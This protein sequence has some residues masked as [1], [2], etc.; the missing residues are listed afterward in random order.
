MADGRAQRRRCLTWILTLLALGHLGWN[1][2]R[3]V[4]GGVLKRGKRIS[5][6]REAGPVG[7]HFD[8]NRMA[9]GEL[10]EWIRQH[11]P[12]QCVVLFAGVHQD[13]MELA[14]ALLAPRVLV[15]ADAVAPEA[16]SW[17]SGGRHYPIA[18]GPLPEGG[19]GGLWLLTGHGNSLTLEAR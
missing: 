19:S 12:D 8:R 2:A 16:V 1:G 7:W 11:S 6:W 9:G 4:S 13:A 17:E 14:A 18:G 10:V 15:S 3:L 5:G